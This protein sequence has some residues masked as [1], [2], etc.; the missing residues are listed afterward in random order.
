ML[1]IVPDSVTPWTV[2]H[3]AFPIWK[4]RYL[5]KPQV[6]QHW[7]DTKLQNIHNSEHHAILFKEL[8]AWR[9]LL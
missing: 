9:T 4:S 8:S 7:V 1:S 6:P 2:I 3:Q 5:S